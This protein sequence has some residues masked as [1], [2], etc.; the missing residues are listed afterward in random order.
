M[1]DTEALYVAEK[2]GEYILDGINYKMLYGTMLVRESVINKYGFYV[3]NGV[4]VKVTEE[5]KHNRTIYYYWPLSQ[6]TDPMTA[7]G[8]KLFT[9]RDIDS[10]NGNKP[11]GVPSSHTSDKRIGCIP[12]GAEL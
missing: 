9:I 5:A 8:R 3:L 1:S 6:T 12:K 10:L 11:Q 2:E 7:G 4:K